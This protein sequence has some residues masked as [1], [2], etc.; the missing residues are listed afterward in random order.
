MPRKRRK[1]WDHVTAIGLKDKSHQHKVE[2]K[3]CKHVFVG[4]ASRIREHFLHINIACGVAKCTSDQAVLQPVL[5][6]M[7]AID[8]QNKA[9]AGAAAAQRQLDK[10]TA[11]N[12]SRTGVTFP[13]CITTAGT[14]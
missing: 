6:E 5:D 2:C 3:Y 9:A 13:S 12:A 14:V 1:E 4:G 8:A 10:S 7:R 11:T